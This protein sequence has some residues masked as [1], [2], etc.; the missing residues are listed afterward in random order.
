[1]AD[2]VVQPPLKSSLLSGEGLSTLMLLIVGGLASLGLITAAEASD[3][4]ITLAK[5]ITAGVT[6]VTSAGVVWKFVESRTALKKIQLTSAAIIAEKKVG[7]SP[8]VTTLPP[9]T[10]AI[11]SSAVTAN[12]SAWP[13]SPKDIK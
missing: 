10:P 4:K 6:L 11:P 5:I 2:E 8:I 9:D 7:I 13:E 12:C 1:M 3:L